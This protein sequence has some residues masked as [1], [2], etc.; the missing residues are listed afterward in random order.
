[1]RICLFLFVLFSFGLP[2]QESAVVAQR[3]VAEVNRRLQLPADEQRF[4]GEAVARLL[5]GDGPQFV[6]VVDRSPQVQAFLL[7]WLAADG[8][9]HWIG[10]SPVSTGHP[11]RFDYFETPL[12][13][14]DHTFDNPD[15]RAEGTRNENGI[16]GYGAKG[17]RVYDFG[18]VRQN[19]GWG[20][21]AEI[22]MRFQMHATDPDF[23]EP[24]LGTPQSKGCVRIPATLNRFLDRYGILD[25]DYLRVVQDGKRP[26]VLLPDWQPV[27]NA[28]RYL[29][30]ID[31]D[32]RTRPDWARP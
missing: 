23:L 11:G 17:M 24:K 21:R 25:A 8:Q 2:A 19:K 13:V 6:A 16:C 29:I 31:T 9:A 15:Y 5:A 14:F 28:G 3:Y 32:R 26:G 20:D 27:A 22:E 1:M 7:Y 4:Y 12:G 18:W 10:A 30:V